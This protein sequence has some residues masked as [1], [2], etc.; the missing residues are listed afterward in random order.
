MKPTALTRRAV[1]REALALIDRDGVDRFSIR[2]LANQLGV[3]P[4]AL[5]NHVNGK[6]DLLQAVAERVVTEAEYRTRDGDWKKVAAGAFELSEGRVSRIRRG[7][8]RGI[9]EGELDAGLS[10]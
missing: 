9:S 5:Y 10:R 7:R 6:R 2:R 3:T 1:V 4:M 8:S